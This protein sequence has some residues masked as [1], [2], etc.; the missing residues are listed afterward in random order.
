MCGII[1]TQNTKG[2][3]NMRNIM[4]NSNAYKEPMM[5]VRCRSGFRLLIRKSQYADWMRT[6]ASLTEEQVA[7][8]RKAFSFFGCAA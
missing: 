3:A 6:E 8:E 1:R 7:E 5:F 4:E 2:D